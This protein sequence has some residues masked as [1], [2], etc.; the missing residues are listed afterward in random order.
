M[1]EVATKREI[2]QPTALAVAATGAR[3]ALPLAFAVAVYALVFGVLA[4]TAG[5]TI[6]QCLAM[7]A[8]VFA[9]AAQFVAV[10]MWSNGHV[11][12]AALAIATLAINLRYL[13]LTAS[14][15]TILAS[16]R[17]TRLVGVHLVVDENWALAMALPPSQRR[18]AFLIGSGAAIYFAWNAGGLLGFVFG[19]AMP[20]PELIG[21]DFAFTAAFL[22]L[23]L[24]MWR[25]ASSDLVPWATTALAAALAAIYLPANWH[26]VVGVAVGVATLLVLPYSGRAHD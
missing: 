10:G 24:S 21:L 7:N 25:G 22:S 3:A 18:S 13:A 17:I 19:R 9:G 16:F 23:A 15:R 6:A 26:I 14:L 8:L 2:P 1:I 4:R 20:D 5:M 12:L 11:P